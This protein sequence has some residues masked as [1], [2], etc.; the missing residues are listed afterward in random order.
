[1]SQLPLF[2]QE[3]DLL[4]SYIDGLLLAHPH[5]EQLENYPIIVDKH[6]AEDRVPILSGGGSGHEPAHIGFVGQGMLTAAVYGKIFIPPTPE[7][8]LRAIRHINRG[9]G[10]FVI[11]KNFEADL[12]D[13]GQA[14]KQARQEGIDVRYI[15]SHDDISV[16]PKKQF[17]MRHRGLAGTI[18]LH[19]ILGAAAQ[20]GASLAELE[21]LGLEL[22]TEIATIGFA[23]SSAHFPGHDQPLFQLEKGKISYGMGIHGEEGYRTVTFES[24]EQLANEIVNKLKIKFHWREGEDYI[25]LVNNLG[26]VSEL[27]LGIFTNAICQ[28]LD[29]QGLQLPFI[30]QGRLMTSLDMAGI[31]VTLCRL[32]DRKWLDY[33]LADTDAAAW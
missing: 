24:A 32:K 1:M 26:T 9:Q 27:E 2:Y 23:T 28:F 33:L 5:L 7:Q 8:I 22:A 4:Q 11:V 6:Q 16:E 29:L 17:Q 15:V 20:A 12:A 3:E 21:A 30:K 31:S 19:K 14:I 10:V 13:F 25:L 18:F